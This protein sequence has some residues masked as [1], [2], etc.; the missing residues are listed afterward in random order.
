[1]NTPKTFHFSGKETSPL[2]RS[3]IKSLSTT[4]TIMDLGCGEGGVLFDLIQHK[5]FSETHKII[6]VDNDPA[7]LKITQKRLG[8]KVQIITDDVNKLKKLQDNSCDLICC[9][10]VIE[11][12]EEPQKMI[13][14]IKRCLKPNGLLYLTT[15]IRKPYGYY[16]Y[17]NA[18]GERTL[19]PAHIH[20]FANIPEITDLVCPQGFETIQH[21]KKTTTFSVLESAFQIFARLSWLNS[22]NSRDIFSNYRFLN[23]LRNKIKVPIIG[24]YDF[25]GLFRINNSN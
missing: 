4:A 3:A 24:F 8:K 13:A 21:K 25:E 11:H 22:A 12:L 10:M 7:R 19:D 18:N 9:L 6:A 14:Q 23:F 17:K 1:M 2:L 5:T 15:I 20:E 16:F